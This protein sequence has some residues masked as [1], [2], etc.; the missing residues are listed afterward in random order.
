VPNPTELFMLLNGFSAATQ[1]PAG[2]RVK[3]VVE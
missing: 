2:T 3:L 1:I